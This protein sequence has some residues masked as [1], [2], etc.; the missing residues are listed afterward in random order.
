MLELDGSDAGGQF[1]RRALALSILTDTPVT[2]EHVRGSRPEPGLKPQ[3]LAAVQAAADA[4]DGTVEGARLGA[5]TVSLD[6]GRLSGGTVTAD[7]QTAGSVTLVFDT[8]LPL[9]LRIDDPLTVRAT[10]GTDVA[11]SPPMTWYRH[12]KLPLLRDLGV[13]VA[14]DVDRTGFY[15]VGGGAATL[16]L[17]PSDPAPLALSD[18]GSLEGIRVYSKAANGLAD[19]EVAERQAEAVLEQFDDDVT[20]LERTISYVDTDS[21]GTACC[22]RADYENGVAGASALGEKGKPAEEVGREAASDVHS[23]EGTNAAVDRYLADQLLVVLVAAGGELTIP[24]MT[25]HVE[26]SLALF[27]AFGESVDVSEKDERVVLR[28]G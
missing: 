28:A 7:I 8:L 9:A 24:T 21:P 19:A 3:H 17:N 14:V 26:T 22:V 18:R 10:G 16:S 13:E 2:V 6:P 5:E 20:V 1:L 12:V 4:C 11:W 23:F 15:P 25:N 27:E